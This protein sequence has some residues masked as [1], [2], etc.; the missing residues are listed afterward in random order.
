MAKKFIPFEPAWWSF[1][2]PGYGDTLA[3]YTRVSGE[4][5]PPLALNQFRGEFQWLEPLEGYIDEEMAV[6]RDPQETRREHPER[7]QAVRHQAAGIGMALPDSFLKL[8][9][10]MQLQDRI[11][12]CT[13]CYFD[14]TDH[15]VN[16]PNETDRHLIRFLSDQQGCL[17]WYL[18]LDNQDE[19]GVVVSELL[20]D[21]P[22]W[23]NAL[24]GKS[25]IDHIKLCG[26][27]LEAFIYRF[28]IENKIWF[29]LDD[30]SA[31]LSDEQRSYLSFFER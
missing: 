17:F 13:A 23:Q 16:S 19:L 3:T 9:D 7:L 31:S 29:A 22:G 28:W 25:V 1:G 26:P 30:E 2:L 18:Y 4:Y 5:L 11:P 27:S 15:I 24:H 14:L 21:E 20:L 6:H 12:S 8:M 10:S